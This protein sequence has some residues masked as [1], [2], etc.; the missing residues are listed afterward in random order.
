[1]G[2]RQAS[3]TAPFSDYLHKK[4]NKSGLKPSSSLR[5]E[6]HSDSTFHMKKLHILQ[7]IGNIS[8]RDFEINTELQLIIFLTSLFLQ[9]KNKEPM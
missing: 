9:E 7:I 2:L 3:I 6:T 5:I 8:E 4:Y 1:M